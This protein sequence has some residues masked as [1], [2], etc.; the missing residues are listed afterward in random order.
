MSEGRLSQAQPPPSLW[1]ASTLRRRVV[2]HWL[3]EWRAAENDEAAAA[4]DEG[5]DLAPSG[6]R[7]GAAV[8]KNEH[9]VLGMAESGAQRFHRVERVYL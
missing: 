4:L 3:M 1:F 6:K 2:V 5:A 8:R 7:E 9:R